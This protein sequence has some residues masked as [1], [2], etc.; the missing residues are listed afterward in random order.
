M[1]IQTTKPEAHWNYFL[2]IERDLEIL[3][4][5]VEFDEKNFKC[6]SIE[7]ARIALAAGAE[8]DVVC[9]QMCLAANPNSKA[10]DAWGNDYFDDVY[11]RNNVPEKFKG[12]CTDVFFREGLKFAEGSGDQPFFL[13]LPLNAPHG[14]LWFAK[15]T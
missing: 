4:R 8:V 15:T 9:K 3:S 14:P 13:F 5:Y 7:I 1:A 10:A 12:Y 2:A 6:F 11:S